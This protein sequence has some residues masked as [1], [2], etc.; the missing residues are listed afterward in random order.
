VNTKFS[1]P[2]KVNV[3]KMRGACNLTVS[4]RNKTQTNT[5]YSKR[6][7]RDNTG[8]WKIHFHIGR[9]IFC[10]LPQRLILRSLII[11]YLRP[12]SPRFPVRSESFHCSADVRT[13]LAYRSISLCKSRAKTFTASKRR[14]SFW[15]RASVI[16][17]S[18]QS[19]RVH[20]SDPTPRSV[21]RIR[22]TRLY[23]LNCQAAK[24]SRRFNAILPNTFVP[25]FEQSN[26]NEPCTP[27]ERYRILVLLRSSGA[28]RGSFV[29]TRSERCLPWL[30]L[31]C[32]CVCVC[33]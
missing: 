8:N 24:H 20:R 19:C 29:K 5:H 3:R 12:P 26:R 10:R 9:N 22:S 25:V 15:N 23:A 33:V 18:P 13:D 30:R 2:S 16:V 31:F 4:R 32:V 7:L 1:V 17:V 21:G 27:S 6:R 14:N 28:H 11:R